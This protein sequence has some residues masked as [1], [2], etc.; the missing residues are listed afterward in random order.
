MI[1]FD[2]KSLQ[3]SI[4]LF[5]AALFWGSAFVA[6]KICEDYPNYEIILDRREAIKRAIEV[7][8]ENDFWKIYTAENGNEFYYQLVNNINLT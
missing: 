1:S 4:F 7:A 6:Q 5:F 3:G 8:N 2:K